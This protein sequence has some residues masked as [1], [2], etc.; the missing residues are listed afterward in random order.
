[1]I[2]P[3]FAI[4]QKVR[5]RVGNLGPHLNT[6]RY[7]GKDLFCGMIPIA[8][9]INCHVRFQCDT[10]FFQNSSEKCRISFCGLKFDKESESHR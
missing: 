1:M 5:V 10:R 3:S 9:L 4:L 6:I 8:A 2:S 7:T